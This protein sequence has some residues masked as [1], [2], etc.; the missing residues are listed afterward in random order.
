MTI[1]VSD[2]AIA[3]LSFGHLVSVVAIDSQSDE[4][5][6]SIPSSEGQRVLA[7]FVA[8]HF[9]ACGFEV[10]RDDQANVIASRPG[11]K[12]GGPSSADPIA[13]LVHLDTARGTGH[14]SMLHRVANW[15]GTRVPFPNNPS[16]CVDTAHYASLT[17][18]LGQTIVH[19]D[20]QIPFGLDDK[21]GLTH[22]MTLARLI[23]GDPSIDHPPL[24]LIGRPDEEI[25]RM[26]AVE[27]L[28]D[29]LARRGVRS[30]FTVDGILP[31]EVNVANFNAAHA[32]VTFIGRPTSVPTGADQRLE[33]LEVVLN[34]VNTHGATANAEGHRT[35]VRF[36]AELVD[37][38]A[39]AG[40]EVHP[41]RLVSDAMRD[42][43]GV[44]TLLARPG[45]RLA[46]E[47]MTTA[48]V[49]PHIPRGASFEVRVAD[50]APADLILDDAVSRM[51]ASVIAFAKSRPVDTFPLWA[52]DSSG[53]QGYSHAYRVHS[54]TEHLDGQ[55]IAVTALTLDIRIRDFD[56]ATL[57]ARKRHIADFFGAFEHFQVSVAL[58]D[59]YVNMGPRLADR[60]DLVEVAIAAGRDIGVEVL[61]MPIRGGTGVDPF[62]DRGTAIANLGTGY[63]A[64]ESEK[65]L[66][67]VELM[68]KHARWLVAL[69]SRLA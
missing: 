43:D 58:R 4:T 42:C 62:L 30:G 60:K 9:T 13:L 57:E 25:G 39:R 29:E 32:S 47:G 27:S 50:A 49:G 2:S 26:E 15:D 65:E 31:F 55:D 34:G 64:P 67:T 59:Q 48:I 40:I 66:T 41:A 14:P 16:I 44:L 28:A 20:G 8:A 33:V 19:G 21:L 24:L 37:T 12:G 51:L 52:E 18:F 46:I 23:H 69:L 7:D 5:S 68:A 45:D 61:D 6:A 53:W 56:P 38:L 36:A 22:L 63:F 35:A 1:A 11:R 3:E 10:S 17:P 54:K